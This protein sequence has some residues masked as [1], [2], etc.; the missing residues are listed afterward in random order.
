LAELA[1]LERLSRQLHAVMIAQVAA[2]ERRGLPA[3]LGPAS[4]RDLLMSVLRIS[5]T[6]ATGRVAPRQHYVS[7]SP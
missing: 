5:H 4:T 6:D 2:V 1:G 7:S 3:R